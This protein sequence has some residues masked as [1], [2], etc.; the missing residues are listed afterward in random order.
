MAEIL[1]DTAWASA[2]HDALAEIHINR[3][4]FDLAEQHARLAF[5]LA[6]PLA[7]PRKQA[8][9]LINLGR[10]YL[11]RHRPDLAQTV[12]A[13]ALTITQTARDR[14]FEV[15]AHIF[16]GHSLGAADEWE[17]ALAHFEEALKGVMAYGDEVGTGVVRVNL[18]RAL[19]RLGRLDEAESQIKAGLQ[20][21]QAADNRP[22]IAVAQ[23]L[24]VELAGLRSTILSNV[25][26]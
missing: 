23:G 2:L 13:Q 17:R 18:G 15:K 6:R 1:A 4:Q 16:L 3:N 12:L 11:G 26:D 21:H 14:R 20:I 7:D 8:D 9:A 24:L 22:S 10:A 5:D 19:L 25:S